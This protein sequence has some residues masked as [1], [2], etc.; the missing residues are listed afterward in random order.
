MENY[1]GTDYNLDLQS[2]CV[3][4]QTCFTL[5]SE[6]GDNCIQNFHF[7]RYI[8]GYTVGNLVLR[9][10]ESGAIKRDLRTYI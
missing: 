9:Q 6:I 3:A 10:R 2:H 4:G 8:V 7:G 1:E 5:N